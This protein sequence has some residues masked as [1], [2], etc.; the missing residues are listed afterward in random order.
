VG[1][2]FPKPGQKKKPEKTSCRANALQAKPK[3]KEKK[4]SSLHPYHPTT[5]HKE[6]RREKKN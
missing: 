1:C 2:L 4:K 5:L 6:R 3:L